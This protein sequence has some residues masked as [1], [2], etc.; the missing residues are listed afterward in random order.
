MDNNNLITEIN[1]LKQLIATLQQQIQTQKTEL[2]S[3]KQIALEAKKKATNHWHWVG[4]D[5]TNNTY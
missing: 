2:D 5:K 3:V 4:T 1:K